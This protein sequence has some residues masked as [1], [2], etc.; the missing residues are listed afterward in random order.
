M[1]GVNISSLEKNKNVR[2]L[3]GVCDIGNGHINRQRCIINILLK[4]NVDIVL[5]VTKRSVSSFNSLYPQLKKVIVSIP[6]VYCNNQG[7][8]FVNTLNRYKDANE[9][10][11]KSFL[12]FAVKVQECFE[13]ELPDLVMSD[14]EPNVAQFAYA[15]DI[16]L[17]GMEQQSKM[18]YIDSEPLA[19]LTINEEIARLKYFFPKVTDRVISSFFPVDRLEKE[20]VIVL[21]PILKTIKKVAPIKNKVIVYF[22][23]YAD[24]YEQFTK[25]LELAKKEG[26]YTFYVYTKLEFDNYKGVDNIIFKR[27]SD[28]FNENISDCNLIISSSGHQL[29]SEAISLEKPLFI[30]SF[31]TFEQNYNALM[32]EKFQLGVKG[33]EFSTDEF[34]NFVDSIET[35]RQNMISYKQQYWPNSWDETFIDVLDN[36]YGI[37]FTEK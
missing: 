34:E 16:P 10:L 17:I 28:E 33:K 22:S 14:Y 30:F 32:V 25:V 13:G 37:H 26:K 3:I 29:I 27:I 21:P 5:A 11:Y 36:K 7:V 8:D 12:E 4:C 31:H 9:D 1:C 20:N 18:L 6:W 15:C 24:D 2:L 23:S 19:G 35:Y